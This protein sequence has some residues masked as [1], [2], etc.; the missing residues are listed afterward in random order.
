MIP[1]GHCKQP[2]KAPLAARRLRRSRQR[3]VEVVEM[4]IVLPLFL[5]LL[6]GILDISRLFFTEITLQRA[7]REGGRFGVTGQQLADPAH[8]GSLQTRLASIKQIV[9]DS[10]VGVHV[11][12]S[13]IVI[14]SVTGGANSA[15]GPGDT[16]TI[17]L[18]YTFYFATPLI[19]HYFNNGSHIF[20][21]SSSFHNEPFP[22]GG[23]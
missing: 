9:V 5:F 12:P 14:N 10:A 2:Y 3:G 8:Q 17:T 11:D 1:Q 22:P 19:G 13:S 4:A 7:M 18:T 15:G 16:F 23:S 21:A 20:T 6:F